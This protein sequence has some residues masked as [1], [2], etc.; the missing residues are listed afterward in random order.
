MIGKLKKKT[1]GNS[2]KDCTCLATLGDATQ[3]C[4]LLLVSHQPR[5]LGQVG[6]AYLRDEIIGVFVRKFANANK[7][8]L[9]AHD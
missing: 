6:V 8:L 3:I 7:A 9:K 2:H 1:V 5:K 4:S